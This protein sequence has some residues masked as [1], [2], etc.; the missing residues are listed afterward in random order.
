MNLSKKIHLN[1]TEKILVEMSRYWLTCLWQYLLGFLALF[2]GSFFMFQLFSLGLWGSLLYWFAMVSGFLLLVQTWFFQKTNKLVITGERV[3]DIHRRGWFDEE[4]SSV[5]HLEIRDVS[6]RKKGIFQ[7]LF[8]FGAVS[9][10]TRSS[11][12]VLD[13]IKI[14]DPA[15]VQTLIQEASRQFR[16]SAKLVSN[17]SIFNN[18]LR[19]IPELTDPQ[20]KEAERIIKEQ[21]ASNVVNKDDGGMI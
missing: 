12:I 15:E 19:I 18:F 13:I 8:N 6:A 17:E 20:L 1:E 16:H 3:V 9:I 7:N 2:A 4:I 21:F 5:S 11:Q 14:K 10:Q